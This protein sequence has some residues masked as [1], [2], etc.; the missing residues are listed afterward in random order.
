MALLGADMYLNELTNYYVGLTDDTADGLMGYVSLLTYDEANV[1][2]GAT[3]GDI[4]ELN[5]STS[6]T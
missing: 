3:A 6:N 5:A 4:S 1:G 2:D